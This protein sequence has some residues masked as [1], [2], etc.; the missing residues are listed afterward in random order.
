M[1]KVTFDDENF[2]YNYEK[3]EKLY[4]MRGEKIKQ[5]K[6]ILVICQGLIF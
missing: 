4:F 6:T 5:F 2:N 3:N 1:K